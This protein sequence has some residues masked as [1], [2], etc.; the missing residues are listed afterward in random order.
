[1]TAGAYLHNGLLQ[2]GD[3]AMKII[4]I[5]HDKGQLGEKQYEEG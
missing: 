3:R 1:M 5:L 2:L 4:N